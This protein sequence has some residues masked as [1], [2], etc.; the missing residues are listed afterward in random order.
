MLS[1]VHILSLSVFSPSNIQGMAGG[2]GQNIF[3]SPQPHIKE[4]FVLKACRADIALCMLGR[5]LIYVHLI[6]PF[7]GNRA[8]GVKMRMARIIGGH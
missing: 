3:N 1:R 2:C 7:Y 5:T 8:L 4:K 6:G